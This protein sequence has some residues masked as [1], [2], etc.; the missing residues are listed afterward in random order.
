MNFETVSRWKLWPI[1]TKYKALQNGRLRDF[2]FEK[3]LVYILY[4]ICEQEDSYE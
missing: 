2:N 3:N 4:S 1:I